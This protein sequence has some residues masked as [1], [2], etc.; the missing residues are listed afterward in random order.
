LKPR[1]S[2]HSGYWRRATLAFLEAGFHQ[3]GVHHESG[4]PKWSAPRRGLRR[5]VSRSECFQEKCAFN[6]KSQN[7]A[8]LGENCTI[9]SRVGAEN[10]NDHDAR[11]DGVPVASDELEANK[12]EDIADAVLE[13]GELRFL[14]LGSR[15][16]L[17][18]G[19]SC[20]Q[21]TA[22]CRDCPHSGVLIALES[23]TATQPLPSGEVCVRKAFVGGPSLPESLSSRRSRVWKGCSQQSAFRRALYQCN[24]VHFA[25]R[26]NRPKQRA[27]CFQYN[28]CIR[29]S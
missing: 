14:L 1:S 7:G 26:P 4:A 18:A 15:T 20:R 13:Q 10:H 2:R 27:L 9:E 6:V 24:S 3:R 16:S 23:A 22:C 29:S 21:R 5:R 11:R 12:G 19:A 17:S 28:L 25:M 8:L